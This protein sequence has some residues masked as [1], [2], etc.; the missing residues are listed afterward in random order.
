MLINAAQATGKSH[1]EGIDKLTAQLKNGN[2]NPGIGSK[3]IGQGISE[4]RARDGARV[5]FRANRNTIEIL[6]KSN[7]ANQAKVIQ[8]VIKQF[9]GK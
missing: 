4:A 6:G 5:Y 8:E 3:P 2:V 9:G 1:Q 7:K